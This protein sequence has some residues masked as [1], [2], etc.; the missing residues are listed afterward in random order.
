M[1]NIEVLNDD[2][3]KEVFSWLTLQQKCAVQRVKRQWKR[4]IDE[5]I[6]E[7]DSLELVIRYPKPNHAVEGHP[8]AYYLKELEDIYKSGE[9]NDVVKGFFRKF[10][11]KE[12]SSSSLT[13]TNIQNLTDYRII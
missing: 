5:M 9:L 8:K 12:S 13:I 6:A 1:A 7:E 3:L 11:N 4:V 10:A 2:C